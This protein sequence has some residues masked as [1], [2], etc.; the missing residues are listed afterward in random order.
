[1]NEQNDCK[2]KLLYK[3][4]SGNKLYGVFA[5][6]LFLTFMFLIIYGSKGLNATHYLILHNEI[7]DLNLFNLVKTFYRTTLLFSFLSCFL[8]FLIFFLRKK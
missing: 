7:D 4:K 5:I 3:L 2:E 6:A 8:S 1:M